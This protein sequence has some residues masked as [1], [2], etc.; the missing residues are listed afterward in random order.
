MIFF[1]L[2][3]I[4]NLQMMGKNLPN[5]WCCQTQKNKCD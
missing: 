1:S 3:A 2:I 4:S 5:D